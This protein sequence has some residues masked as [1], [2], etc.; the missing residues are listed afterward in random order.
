MDLYDIA[1]AKAIGG[2]SGGGGGISGFHSAAVTLENSDTANIVSVYLSCD[3]EDTMGI[4][5]TGFIVHEDGLI[6][7]D[8]LSD[9]LPCG[10]EKVLSVYILDGKY[11][12]VNGL[13]QADEEVGYTIVGNA[14]LATYSGVTYVRVY[15]DCRIS[16][17]LAN[18]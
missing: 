3:S 18:A 1:I 17:R 12:M 6:S 9:S 13:T 16:M 4:G 8:G 7:S 10:T 15:G 2:D 5:N 11:V 14:E